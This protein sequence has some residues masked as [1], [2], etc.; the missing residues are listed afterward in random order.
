[1][2]TKNSFKIS[3]KPLL[4]IGVLAALSMI[5]AACATSA[6]PASTPSVAQPA[7]TQSVSTGSTVSIDVGTD[8]TLGKFL[9]DD[10][11]RPLYNWLND[12]KP[13][14]TTG[15]GVG[16]VWYVVS[17]TGQEDAPSPESIPTQAPAAT[18]A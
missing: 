15:Q 1:M 14:D 13:G 5:L 10:K 8:P 7:I 3:N 17:P 11:G 4:L 6:T 2:N 18:F 16:G 9:V 12:T